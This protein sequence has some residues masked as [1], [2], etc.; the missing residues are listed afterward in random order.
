MQAIKTAAQGTIKAFTGFK[1]LQYPREL[2]NFILSVIIAVQGNGVLQGHYFR[3]GL[4]EYAYKK[5]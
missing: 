4:I 2:L 1:T 3:L 5:K